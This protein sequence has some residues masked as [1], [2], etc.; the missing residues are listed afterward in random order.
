MQ[1]D[2]CSSPPRTTDRV[3]LGLV[4]KVKLWTRS[5]TMFGNQSPF[6]RSDGRNVRKRER[7]CM[8]TM[9]DERSNQN[10]KRLLPYVLWV[11][12]SGQPASTLLHKKEADTS[13]THGL[14]V[15]LPG[16]AGTW[17]MR[18]FPTGPLSQP[19]HMRGS[20]AVQPSVSIPMVW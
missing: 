2:V 11:C 15:G 19:S 8:Y 3:V 7:R 12:R 16:N 20:C 5:R 1:N 14:F 13:F 18:R 10:R 9:R 6:A 17:S 4:L